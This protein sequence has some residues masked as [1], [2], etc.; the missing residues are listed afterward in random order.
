M[1]V[2]RALDPV[3]AAVVEAIVVAAGLG[4]S[5]SRLVRPLAYS[6]W[7]I[8]AKW[9]RT[10]HRREN[11]THVEEDASKWRQSQIDPMGFVVG[12]AGIGNCWV[13]AA[14]RLQAR[15]VPSFGY[16]IPVYR[17]PHRHGIHSHAL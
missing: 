8:S 6:T 17:I 12:V 2:V 11:H 4:V 9:C 13:V 7:W 3:E 1:G 5:L 15:L 10:Q 14:V 16:R